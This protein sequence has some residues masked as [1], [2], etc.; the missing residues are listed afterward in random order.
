MLDGAGVGDY[1]EG[2]S[3][4]LQTATTVETMADF[5]ANLIEAGE[6]L[7][8]ALACIERLVARCPA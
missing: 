1:L 6:R 5:K 4:D 2:A 7:R 3:D 8:K